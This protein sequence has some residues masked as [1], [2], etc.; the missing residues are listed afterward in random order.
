[1]QMSATVNKLNIAELVVLC[2]DTG[3]VQPPS[4]ALK[5]MSITCTKQLSIPQALTLL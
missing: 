3:R 5:H 1:M 2:N 4:L